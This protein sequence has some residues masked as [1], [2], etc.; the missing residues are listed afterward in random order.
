MFTD[1]YPL[2]CYFCQLIKAIN[3][4]SAVPKSLDI[5][6]QLYVNNRHRHKL[7]VNDIPNYGQHILMSIKSTACFINV[8]CMIDVTDMEKWTLHHFC[9]PSIHYWGSRLRVP[10]SH[11]DF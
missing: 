11:V 5:N 9:N 8:N 4:V 6:Q 7:D 1:H 2:F 10:M 3:S